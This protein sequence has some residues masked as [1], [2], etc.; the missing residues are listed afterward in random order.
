MI[1]MMDLVI[2][3]FK[4]AIINM[5]KILNIYMSIMRKEIKTIIELQDLKNTISEIKFSRWVDQTLQTKR[6]VNWKI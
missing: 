2:K 1:E 5:L 6:S 4:T 3:N